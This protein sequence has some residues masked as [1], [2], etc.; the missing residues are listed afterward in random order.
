MPLKTINW[1]LIHFLNQ[2]IRWAS[3]GWAELQLTLELLS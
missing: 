3:F 2:Q 1:E